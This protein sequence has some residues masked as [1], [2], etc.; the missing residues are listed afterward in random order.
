MTT[1][2]HESATTAERRRYVQTHIEQATR[3]GWIETYLQPITRTMTGQVCEFEVL[4]RWNDPRYG[5]LPPATF[6]DALESSG[7]IPI[8]DAHVIR[9]ACH[10][11]HEVMRDGP[12]MVPLSVNLS[13][14]NFGLCDVFEMVDSA[15]REYEV[16]RQ[17]LRVEITESA[18]DEDPNALMSVLRRF[19]KAGHQV[20]LDDFGS[21]Y[22][23][24]NALKDYEFD[25]IKLD[26][27]FMREFETKPRSRVIVASIINMAKQLGTQTLTEG[28]E[29]SGQYEFLREIGCEFA[30]G[31]LIGKPESVPDTL[32][33]IRSEQLTVNDSMLHG[34]YD[35]IGTV[36]ALSATPFEFPWDETSQK[37]SMIDVIPLA[38]AERSR[39]GIELL[40]AN[41]SMM[42]LARRFSLGRLPD[43]VR[44]VND[45]VH[46]QS[47]VIRDAIAAAI[48]SSKTETVH[49]TSETRGVVMR[50]R[51]IAN[52]DDVDAVL[53][54]AIALTDHDGTRSM[55]QGE[56]E[57][58][59]LRAMM[60]E[61]D[62]MVADDDA[63][64]VLYRKGTRIPSIVT[65]DSIK[66]SVTEFVDRHV[67]PDDRTRCSAHLDLARIRHGSGPEATG[68]TE[69]A[70]RVMGNHGTYLWTTITIIP[71]MTKNMRMALTC[72]RLTDEGLADTVTGGDQIPKST[73]W[74]A[75][76][77]LVPAGV[78]WKG[79]D[80]R[81]VGTNER[82][83]RFY[84][85]DSVNDVLGRTDE[86]MGWHVR[87]GPFKNDE[88]RVIE[89]GERILGAR[90]TCICDGTV[91]DIT[92]NKVPLRRGGR[93]IGLLGY[94]TDVT[95]PGPRETLVND[96]TGMPT[97]PGLGPSM[98]RYRTAYEAG[99][100]DFAMTLVRTRDDGESAHVYGKA[101]SDRVTKTVAATIASDVGVNGIVA[102][103]EDTT[104]LAVWQIHATEDPMSRAAAIR[105]DIEAIREVD[106]LPTRLS[107]VTGTASY[108]ETDDVARC[109]DLARER[110]S[111]ADQ[112]EP[113][114][115]R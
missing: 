46:E 70:F 14:A 65:S 26:M 66:A 93:T 25:V 110:M 15:V 97:L 91:H 34:Y 42:R 11:W 45:P 104:F 100:P 59:G 52:H 44:Y 113:A 73:L 74:D 49:V 3:D 77:D 90:G 58:T 78:F 81:F 28:V 114:G 105:R 63:V 20:W 101:F 112:E 75:I 56:L 103:T 10:I 109:L 38:I 30:Q 95:E 79:R 9:S 107:C 29:T 84:G 19:R 67:H 4:A 60:D 76:V 98:E 68:V 13:R 41:D 80:R 64:T 5:M 21:G 57:A 27:A 1:A 72:M 54:S 83:L 55:T 85:F 87:N 40:M 39:D 61:I 99:G 92:A 106:E 17:M 12:I 22:S 47:A 88:L 108:S 6:I 86:D 24:L 48:R 102:H 18:I 111:R 43:I 35:R 2:A 16:P 69:D 23:S 51:H 37:N 82:F 62:A 115:E 89:H 71:V 32:M 96:I 8:L 50:I 33:R 31:Y 94:F 36:N 7:L 53:V